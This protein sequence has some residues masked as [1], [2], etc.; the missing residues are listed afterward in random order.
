MDKRDIV[1]NLFQNKQIII[2]QE[3]KV[4]IDFSSRKIIDNKYEN[5]AKLILIGFNIVN[6][7]DR[8]SQIMEAWK[9]CHNVEDKQ[10]THEFILEDLEKRNDTF[11]SDLYNQIG[12]FNSYILGLCDLKR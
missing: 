1:K 12:S 6:I 10:F 9:F 2:V 3:C 5:I 11:I 4:L 7:K 8:N